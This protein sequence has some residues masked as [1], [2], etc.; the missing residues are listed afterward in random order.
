[1]AEAKLGPCTEVAKGGVGESGASS[2]VVHTVEAKISKL[3]VLRTTETSL[4]PNTGVLA[5]LSAGGEVVA[6]II[7]EEGSSIQIEAQP[8]D[9]VIG[10]VHTFPLF[11]EIHCIRLGELYFRLDECDLVT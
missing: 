1:M 11:N 6:G 3:M 9:T 5:M 2:L 4:C 7:T 8:G 10:V